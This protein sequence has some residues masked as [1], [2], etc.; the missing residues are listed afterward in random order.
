MRIFYKYL[1]I[2]AV[3]SLL[4]KIVRKY[5]G[6]NQPAPLFPSYDKEA[7]MLFME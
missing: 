6:G 5:L 4:R 1:K 3:I 7:A 2:K